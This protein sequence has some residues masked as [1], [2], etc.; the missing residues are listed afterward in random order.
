[1]IASTNPVSVSAIGEGVSARAGSLNRSRA[2]FQHGSWP[3]TVSGPSS[4]APACCQTERDLWPL[5][6]TVRASCSDS[7]T[8]RSE[9][10]F[11]ISGRSIGA[12]LAPSAARRLATASV[13]AVGRLGAIDATSVCDCDH[14]SCS[15]CATRWRTPTDSRSAHIP[16]SSGSVEASHKLGSR[17]RTNEKVDRFLILKRPTVD[18]SMTPSRVATTRVLGASR[19]RS[20]AILATSRRSNVASFAQGFKRLHE[21]RTTRLALIAFH[22]FKAVAQNVADRRDGISNSFELEPFSH[23]SPSVLDGGCPVAAAPER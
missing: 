19:Q 5:A 3:G 23:V 9:W 1:M 15:P 22:T 14:P 18:A 4:S 17:S 2:Q 12:G 10:S 7:A 6:W 11:S 8:L 20:A 16:E 21:N 13:S